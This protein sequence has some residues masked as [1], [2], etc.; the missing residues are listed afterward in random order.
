MRSSAMSLSLGRPQ[1]GDGSQRGGRPRSGS[2]RSASPSMRGP[3]EY[4][5]YQSGGGMG[6]MLLNQPPQAQLDG[7]E[8]D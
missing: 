4:R 7:R 5:R 1:S 6:E 3:G 8:L 2:M